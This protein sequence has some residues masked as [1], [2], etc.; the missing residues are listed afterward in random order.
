MKAQEKLDIIR[1][2]CDAYPLSMFPEPDFKEV[3]A[4]LKEKGIS[5]DAVSASNM[6]HVLNGVRKI[7]DE[8]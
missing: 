7:I 5:L 2:W 6:R 1:A 4:A 8:D 3:H